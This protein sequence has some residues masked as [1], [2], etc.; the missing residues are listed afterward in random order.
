MT[1]LVSAKEV[2]KRY[3]TVTGETIEAIRNVSLELHEGEVLAIVGPSGCGK[4][5]LLRLMSGVEAPSEGSIER[6][7]DNGFIVGF[8]FQDASLMRWRTVYDN[9]KLP[10]EVL[11][12]EDNLKKIDEL[13]QMVN[14]TGFERAYP[15]ELSGGMQRRTAIARALVHEPNVLLMDEPLTGID[16]ITKEILETELSY[17]IRKLKVTA[18]LVTHDIGEAVFLGDRVLVMSARPGTVIYEVKVSLPS[19][20]EPAVRA[21]QQFADCCMAIRDRLN[22]LHPLRTR[23]ASN[24][25]KTEIR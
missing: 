20:R 13:I 17:I 23:E 10:L 11:G 16:E 12:K 22:L 4:S 19:P 25:D 1:S 18:V 8:I 21:Q 5:T 14:L 2:G 15:I 24:F 6:R 3:V 9:I 7:Q